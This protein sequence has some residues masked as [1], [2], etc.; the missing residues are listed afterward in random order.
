MSA[1]K[2]S[3]S[4]NT[5]TPVH[6]TCL[7]GNVSITSL[8]YNTLRGRPVTL[9]IY[10]EF[11]ETVMSVAMTSFVLCDLC[12]CVRYLDQLGRHN[13]VTPTSYLEL[14]SSL[15]TL[16][17]KKQDEVCNSFSVSPMARHFFLVPSYHILSVPVLFHVHS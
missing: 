10:L 6:E 17:G 11:L 15:K 1:K 8:F 3:L 5:S 2:L 9:A 14:I 16:L 12:F 13:Y 4:A 7:K